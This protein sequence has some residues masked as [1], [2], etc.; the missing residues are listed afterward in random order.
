MFS[1]YTSLQLRLGQY[2]STVTFMAPTI[3]LNFSRF[4]FKHYDDSNSQEFLF[5]RRL[6]YEW[7]TTFPPD[8]ASGHRRPLLNLLTGIVVDHK[9]SSLESSSVWNLRVSKRQC[10]WRL[11]LKQ[12]LDA[13]IGTWWLEFDTK[14]R[15]LSLL[16][17]GG[18]QQCIWGVKMR[19]L[20]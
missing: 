11:K 3:M 2:S 18:C 5:A 20:S 8:P 1:H 17:I 10:N 15:Q 19:V 13:K 4:I 12:L 14:A 7:L 6:F 9:N 16:L